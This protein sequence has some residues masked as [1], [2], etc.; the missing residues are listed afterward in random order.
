MLT[1]LVNTDSGL[2]RL[3]YNVS[4]LFIS[5]PEG[6]LLTGQDIGISLDR[7]RKNVLRIWILIQK[8]VIQHFGSGSRRIQIRKTVN[9]L[10]WWLQPLPNLFYCLV[11]L[12]TVFANCSMNELDLCKA[13]RLANTRLFKKLHITRALLVRLAEVGIMFQWLCPQDSVYQ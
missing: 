13:Y 12:V 10:Y 7:I 6:G 4:R 11:Q 8:S 9:Y 3:A 2:P 1:L 5:F